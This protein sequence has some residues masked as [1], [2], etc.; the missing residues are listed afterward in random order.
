MGA[1]VAPTYITLV[2]G[3]LEKNL[4]ETIENRYGTTAKN[5]FTKT[6]NDIWMTVLHFGM[7]E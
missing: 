2:M 1:K 7:R 5:T 6:G 3:Y 4:Y